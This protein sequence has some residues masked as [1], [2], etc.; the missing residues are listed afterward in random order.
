M[1]KGIDILML[2]SIVDLQGRISGHLFWI[3]RRYFAGGISSSRISKIL[4]EG[5]CSPLSF[6]RLMKGKSLKFLWNSLSLRNYLGF[7]QNFSFNLF[8]MTTLFP[9]GMSFHSSQRFFKEY[10]VENI[11]DDL[12]TLLKSR[13]T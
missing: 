5:F 7:H 3:Y 1:K 10:L 12:I 2:F 6:F 13:N 8:L 4:Y 11:L 9:S